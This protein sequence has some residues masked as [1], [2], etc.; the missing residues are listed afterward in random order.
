M[1]VPYRGLRKLLEKI[2]LNHDSVF[3]DYGSGMGR[4][5]AVAATYPIQRIIGVEM[6][7]ELVSTAKENLQSARRVACNN[8]E[9]IET[10]ATEYVVPDDVSIIHFYNPFFGN[11]LKR[12]LD[13]IKDS[14]IR[15]PRNLQLIFFN[16]DHFDRIVDKLDWVQ[17]TFS[18]SVYPETTAALYQVSAPKDKGPEET[19]PRAQ[20]KA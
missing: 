3:L 2:E 1:P 12:V 9:L 14:V 19:T 17:K 7:S 20:D 6:S 15:Q 4:V 18:C 16:H 8:I 13:R 5:V 10:N 11:T